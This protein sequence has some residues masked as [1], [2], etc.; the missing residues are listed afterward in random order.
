MIETNSLPDG[1][2]TLDG[3]NRPVVDPPFRAVLIKPIEVA[4]ACGPLRG[5]DLRPGYCGVDAEHRL[6]ENGFTWNSQMQAWWKYK[7]ESPDA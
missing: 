7:K 1:E 3:Y 4:V 2:G 6:M 5:R